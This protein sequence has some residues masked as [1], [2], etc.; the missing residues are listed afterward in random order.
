MTEDVE[1]LKRL[2]AGALRQPADLRA[3]WLACACPDPT[4]RAEVQTL[5]DSHEHSG[6]LLEGAW[7]HRL[8]EPLVEGPTDSCTGPR[9]TPGEQLGRYVI[10]G[11]LAAG[12]TGEVYRARDSRLI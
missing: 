7:T 11:L 8:S 4:V 12:G 2:F 10:E 1:T 3:A 6:D 5:V 9:F